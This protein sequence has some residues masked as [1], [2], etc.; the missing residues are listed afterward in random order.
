[1]TWLW[2][3]L[4]L[5]LNLQL[6]LIYCPEYVTMFGF[7]CLFG[8]LNVGRFGILRGNV[9]F[10]SQL[11]NS[12]QNCLTLLACA[13]SNWWLSLQNSY[14]TLAW[15]GRNQNWEQFWSSFWQLWQLWDWN[16]LWRSYYS[17]QQLLLWH[18]WTILC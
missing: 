14:Q 4:I 17:H 2:M 8:H 13:S 15:A 16:A 7:I 9:G 12:S 18:Q 5:V 3:V 11:F 10:R 1:M 6:V